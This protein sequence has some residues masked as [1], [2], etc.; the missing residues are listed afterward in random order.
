[1]SILNPSFYKFVPCP[2]G[3]LKVYTIII[4]YLCNIIIDY[5]SLCVCVCVCDYNS[6]EQLIMVFGMSTWIV[7]LWIFFLSL[8]PLI[9][10]I[11]EFALT[12]Q[13]GY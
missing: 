3:S 1:M 8:V 6:L 5:N 2:E 13:M 9:I 7:I 11:L 10:G 4:L 12:K